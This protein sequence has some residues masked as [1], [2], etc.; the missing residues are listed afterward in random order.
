MQVEI[1]KRTLEDFFTAFTIDGAT[2][3]RLV[4]VL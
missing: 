3:K 4:E 1:E 2:G